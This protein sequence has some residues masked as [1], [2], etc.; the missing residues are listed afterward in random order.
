M[1]ASTY[2]NILFLAPSMGM[3]LEEVKV[4]IENGADPAAKKAPSR[5]T[6]SH[7]AAGL[8]RR[9]LLEYYHSIG[10]SVFEEDLSGRT[11]ADSA[12]AQ[13]RW[14]LAEWLDGLRGSTIDPAPDI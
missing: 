10:V 6:P 14:E 8:G 2:S 12:R 1:N 13:G 7:I 11:P 5:G 3:S 9:D 4:E